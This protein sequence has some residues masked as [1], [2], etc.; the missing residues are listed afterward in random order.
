MNVSLYP[1]GHAFTRNPILLTIQSPGTT[2]YHVDASQ[3]D[4][5]R[6]QWI[7]D[8]R[9]FSGVGEGNY[10]VNLAEVAEA[11]VSEPAAPPEATDIITPAFDSQTALINIT[12]T[13]GDSSWT[14]SL[15][16]WRG[17]T[18]RRNYIR[19][20]N[21]GTDIFQTRF[22]NPLNNFFLSARGEEWILTLRETELLP[23]TFIM[24]DG[25]FQIFERLSGHTYTCNQPEGWQVSVPLYLNLQALR[26]HFFDNYHVLPSIFHVR[27]GQRTVCRI[28]IERAK[29]AALHRRVR[30]LNSYGAWDAIQITAPVFA[31]Y[32]STGTDTDDDGSY[33]QYNP[34]DD[35][36]STRRTRPAR[37]TVLTTQITVA[38][39]ADQL[40][41]ADML[42]SDSVWFQGFT[43][44]EV[45]V[46]PAA[47][48]WQRALRL[49]TPETVQVSFTLADDDSLTTAD[50][51]TQGAARPGIFTPQ[52]SEVFN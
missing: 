10:T 13:D 8:R 17:G 31:A 42:Q 19:L 20:K 51:T 35:S 6:H 49:T 36:F 7:P 2:Q 18:A 12:V 41:L 52:F 44:G 16:V 46:I 33:Q 40:L 1:A 4:T 39:H 25:G 23:L 26:R 22:L 48:E 3:Y 15:Q 21:A 34:D 9:I 47:D 24:P 29:P 38:R 14:Q 5:N 37:R 43:A 50:I 30:F 11:A 27:V 32:D 45:R 28:V